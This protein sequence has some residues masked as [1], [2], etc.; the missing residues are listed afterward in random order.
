MV[1]FRG[2]NYL[3]RLQQSSSIVVLVEAERL[4]SRKVPVVAAPTPSKVANS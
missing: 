3:Q 1:Y 4:D 2:G